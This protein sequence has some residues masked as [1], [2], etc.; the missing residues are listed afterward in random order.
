M[1]KKHWMI[2]MA[3]SA[4]FLL[5]A[6]L[7]LAAVVDKNTL[8][9]HVR[10]SYNIPAAMILNLGDLKKSEVPGFDVANMTIEHG[11]MEQTEKLYVSQ[12]GRFYQLGG[13]KDVN[14][15]PDKERLAKINLKQSA[16]RGSKKAPVAVVE[17]T[18]FQCPFCDRGYRM[19]QRVMKEYG[20]KVR[21]VYKSLPLNSIHPWAEPAAVAAECA[22][23]QGDD[24]LWKLHDAFFEK[25]REIN[26]GNIEDRS[27]QFAREAGVNIEAFDKCVAG[28]ETLAKVKSDLAEAESLGINGTPAFIVNG[29]LVGGA[30]YDLLKR[31]IDE[32]LKGKHGGNP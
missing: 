2:R 13:F 7:A 8:L 10:E 9:E 20:D 22:G 27:K 29:H 24:K 18:D 11:E 25:Q 12:D 23:K 6:F 17:Y 16:V 14:V 32:S 5:S 3:A 31:I 26:A 19:M 30:D 21:W 1:H 15:H 28:Q 4:V